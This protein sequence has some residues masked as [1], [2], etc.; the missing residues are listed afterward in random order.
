MK[1]PKEEIIVDKDGKKIKKTE[2]LE[3]KFHVGGESFFN[4]QLK[5]TKKV[6]VSVIKDEQENEISLK[7]RLE[8]FELLAGLKS[9]VFLLLEPFL[10]A[11]V[12]SRFVLQ[13]NTYF[14]EYIFVFV[15]FS[16]SATVICDV[17]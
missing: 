3:K 13:F 17:I 14:V 15:L 16:S 11:E 12:L 4:I 6:Q 8:P 7:V 1:K 5:P 2:V 10:S 9:S